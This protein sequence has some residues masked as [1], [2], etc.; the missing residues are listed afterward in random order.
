MLPSCSPK[1]PR[2]EKEDA[3]WL[4]LWLWVSDCHLLALTF[5]PFTVEMRISGV[6]WVEDFINEQ[7]GNRY[8]HIGRSPLKVLLLKLKLS[9]C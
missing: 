2:A 9:L 8:K 4:A 1:R 5:L 3:S 6:K 7:L